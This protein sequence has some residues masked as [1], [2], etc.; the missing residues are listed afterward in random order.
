MEAQAEELSAIQLFTVE[1]ISE[2]QQAIKLQ[3]TQQLLLRGTQVSL[4][5]LR[6]PHF[7]LKPSLAQQQATD[8]FY[9]EGMDKL[10]LAMQELKDS[11][12]AIIRL[13][14]VAR[15]LLEVSKLLQLEHHIPCSLVH[16]PKPLIDLNHRIL[17]NDYLYQ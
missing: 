5:S 6:L 13:L 17:R 9:L 14:T 11:R 15:M 7:L 10:L 16:N 1:A 12:E 4:H 2:E 8:K 3:V